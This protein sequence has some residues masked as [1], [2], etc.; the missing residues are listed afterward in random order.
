MMSTTSLDCSIFAFSC[1]SNFELMQNNCDINLNSNDY[2]LNHFLNNRDMHSEDNNHDEAIKDI[3]CHNSNYITMEET[4]QLTF[5]VNSFTLLQINCRS[6]KKH[7]SNISHLL[8]NFKSP[9]SIISLSETWLKEKDPDSFFSLEGYIFVSRPRLGGKRGG[10]VGFYISNLLKYVVRSDLPHFIDDVC[11]YCAIELI[12]EHSPNILLVSLYKPPDIDTT[13]FDTKLSKIIKFLSLNNNKKIFLT[14][15]W[16]IDLLKVNYDV[17]TNQFFNNMLSFGLLPTVTIPTRI[18]ERSATLLDN[19]FSNCTH[20]QYYTKV[21][22][23]DISDHLPILLH[24]NDAKPNNQAGIVPLNKYSFR[25]QNF[26]QFHEQ[27]KRTTWIPLQHSVLDSGAVTEPYNEFNEK[28]TKIFNEAFLSKTA[29]G[30]VQTMKGFK[31]PWMTSGLI[32]AC[33]KKSRLL[34]IYKKT[35]SYSS[36]I[37]YINY[38]NTLKKLI[39]QEERAFYEN[40]F[41]SVTQN[42]KQTWKLINSI[43]NKTKKCHAPSF[44]KINSELEFDK[45]KIA[46]SFNNYFVD[47]GPKLASKLIPV[48][49]LDAQPKITTPINKPTIKNSIVLTNTDSAEVFT[50]IS[51]LKSSSSCGHDQISVKVIK[52]VAEWISPVLA[53]LINHSFLTGTFPELLKVA[54]VIPVHKTGDKNLISNYRPISLLNTFSKIYEKVFLN[55]LLSFLNK[56]NIIYANQFGFRKHHS[57]NF[58]LTSF[59][60][61]LTEAL[62]RNEYAVGIFIDLSKAFDTIDHQILLKKL[63]GYGV[64]GLAYNFVESYLK[65]R[66]QY[67]ELLGVSSQPKSIKCGVPQG[68]VLGPVLFIL[69]INDMI[70][71]SN[72]LKFFL[73][74][75]DTT[76]LYYS[77][78]LDDLY[79]TVNTELKKLSLWFFQNK[80]SLNVSKTNYILFNN[81][82]LPVDPPQ[83]L[84]NNSPVSQV[85]STKFLGVEIDDR[86]NW[87]KHI[88]SVENKLS[89]VIF[90]LK[91]IRHKLN[92]TTALNLYHTLILPHLSYCNNVW[93][94]TFKTY[95][96]SL[97]RLQKRALRLCCLDYNIKPDLLF[98]SHNCLPLDFLHKFQVSQIAFK[99]FHLGYTLPECISIL[100]RKNHYCSPSCY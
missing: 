77:K 89:S 41:A 17:K 24:I 84:L 14:A 38:R 5:D 29:R 63:D 70:A 6:L 86:L 87:S 8:S 64:R 55:R 90:I 88:K 51:H 44:L 50:I 97:G 78:N 31:Q 9:P 16:N 91:K 69:Y 99:F 27:V 67:V 30:K 60:D 96:G 1:L 22:Y 18:T 65:D 94:N 73:F 43:L 81:H 21:I 85:S 7:F 61:S 95:L 28:F 42:S 66:S 11:D 62:D 15:D 76:I 12:N 25:K 83:L 32:R 40:K 100:L 20:H 57:T 53:S 39:R 52:C 82:R 92:K 10:G 59:L 93:G 80:L 48:D 46:D 45:E 34:K 13:L 23:D 54:K 19:I 2:N 79:N 74:A 4:S 68:S 37:K 49:P 72:L 3:T 36:R 58:A 26:L 75:D 35:G 98:R 47:L 56:Y 71:C 33:H